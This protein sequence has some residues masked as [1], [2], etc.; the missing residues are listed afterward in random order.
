G[1]GGGGYALRVCHREN[2]DLGAGGYKVE[3]GARR[4]ESAAGCAGAKDCDCES[5]ACAIRAGGG[6]GDTKGGRVRASESEVGVRREYFAGG[7][8]RSVRQRAS[9]DC[10]AGAGGLASDE[11]WAV[12]D[13]SCGDP[14][15]TRASGDRPGSSAEQERCGGVPEIRWERSG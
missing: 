11:R 6:G 7:A 1:K 9:G 15:T 10:G 8:V 3:R 4:M 5:G 12:S 13:D 14:S 2:C